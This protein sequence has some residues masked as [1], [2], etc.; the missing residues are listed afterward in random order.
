[1]RRSAVTGFILAV[2][3]MTLSLTTAAEDFPSRMITIVVPFPAGSATD[4]IARRLAGDLGKDFKVPVVVEN[5]P[6]ADG[7]LAALFT[8]RAKPD[9]Y[10]IFVTTNSTQA[11]NVS[12]YK[13]MPFDPKAD[14]T[15]VAGLVTI[16]MLLTVRADFPAKNIAEF[17]ALARKSTPPLTFGSGNQTGRG[18]GE[19]LKAR[20]GIDMLNVPYT[21][22]PQALTDLI[23]GRIDCF[24]ADPVSATGLAQK[25]LIRV[26]AVTSSKRIATMPDVPTLA[27]SGLPGFELIA[28][29]GAFVN[30][31]TP[32]SVVTRL[33]ASMNTVLTDPPTVGFLATIGA[34][35]FTTTPE[36]LASFAEADTKRWVQIVEVAHIE[37]K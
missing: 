33:N 36:Q 27:E 10:T 15:A 18:A 20:Q 31:K 26:L 6:G 1:M 2:L 22:A 28:W 8:L 5:K 21:G 11:A 24:I 29:V 12:L 16:P 34:T 17:I 25:G 19:L 23:G 13:S 37:K 32:R 35:P 3:T 30:A 4:S 9:G 7:N 14:F